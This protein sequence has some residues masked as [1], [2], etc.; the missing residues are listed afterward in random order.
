[1]TKRSSLRTRHARLFAIQLKPGNHAS[2]LQGMDAMETVA[3]LAGEPH[4]DQPQCT[5]PVLTYFVNRWNDDL[6]LPLRNATLEPLLPRLVGTRMP[7]RTGFE[8]GRA[9]ELRAMSWLLRDGLRTWMAA[10]APG[11]TAKLKPLLD[12]A[13]LRS[14]GDA[15]EATHML[16]ASYPEAVAHANDFEKA[17]KLKLDYAAH[18]AASTEFFRARAASGLV[19]IHPCDLEQKFAYLKQGVYGGV[20]RGLW[21]AVNGYVMLTKSPYLRNFYRDRLWPTSDRIRQ[22]CRRLLLQLCGKPK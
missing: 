10:M 6:P 20:H 8:H 3:W 2:R 16:N 12:F 21:Q 18:M 19:A 11:L 9:R 17:N 15:D 7:G 13:P 22:S 4:S 5:C 14:A 1:M